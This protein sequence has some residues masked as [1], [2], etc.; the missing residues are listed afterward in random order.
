[1][2]KLKYDTNHPT[3]ETE[4]THRHRE[5]TCGFLRWWGGEGSIENLGL[6]DIYIIYRIDKQQGPIV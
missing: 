5:E 2:W 6:A 3:Y 1:M 4:Q